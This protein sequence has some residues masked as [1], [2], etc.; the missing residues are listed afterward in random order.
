MVPIIKKHSMAGNLTKILFS[1]VIVAIILFVGVW[2]WVFKK[3]DVSVGTKKADIEIEA[4]A[5]V[6]SFE[7][8]EN[9]ANSKYLN[10]VIRVTGPVDKIVEGAN[11]VSVYLKK[12]GESSGVSC[13]FDKSVFKSK[14]VKCKTGDLI[15]IKG[16]CSGYL[17]D[18]VLNKCAVEKP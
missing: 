18:V 4:G 7:T 2:S 8:D 17:M 3:S 16:I 10:K 12:K 1:F 15:S 14:N 5:L 11:D 6:E 9:A 13:N